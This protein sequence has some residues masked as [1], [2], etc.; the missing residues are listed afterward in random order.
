MEENKTSFED[1]LKTAKV[2]ELISYVAG[3]QALGLNKDRTILVMKEL[4]KRR[5]DGDTTPYEE[6]IE[7]QTTIIKSIG[8]GFVVLSFNGTPL[9]TLMANIR[10]A[11]CY[12]MPFNREAG[13][14]HIGLPSLQ[15]IE[16]IQKI[17]GVKEV[18]PDRKVLE[19]AVSATV[20]S[21][22]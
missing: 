20:S 3:Y 18:V 16:K 13:M 9:D 1:N 14:I 2:S 4:D 22:G 17:P 10:K 21:V 7:N 11:G 8:K 5:Q 19:N 6:E 12:C 15:L